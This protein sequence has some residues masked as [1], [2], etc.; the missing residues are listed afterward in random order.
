MFTRKLRSDLRRRR[1]RR[2]LGLESLE[3]RRLLSLGAEFPATVNS[4]TNLAQFDSDNASSANGSS[5]AVWTDT[6]AGTDR[7]IRAQRFNSS[8]G[9]V[10]PEIVVSFSGLDEGTPA[11]AMDAQGN[12]V[13]TWMQTQ[14]GGDTNVLA[15]RFNALGTPVGGVVSVGVGT[16]KEHDPDV[17]MDALGNFVV[18]YTRD[19][20][21]TNPDV[22][23]KRFNVSNALLSVT[24]VAITARAETRPSVAMA[25]NGRFNVVWEEA[26]SSTDHDIH[27]NQYAADAVFLG[28]TPI[29]LSTAND[30]LPSLAMDNSGAS[31]VAWQRAGSG[32]SDIKAVRVSSI[33]FAGGEITIAGTSA[34]ERNPSVAL[35]RTGGSFVVAYD[36]T[37]NFI[38]NRVRVAEVSAFNT[39]TTLDA[40]VRSAPAVSI[41][42]FGDY[43]L[44]YTSNDNGDLNI[45]NRRGRLS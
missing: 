1:T 10:G 28:S 2:H 13:V 36:S 8:G 7:D 30:A 31:V 3:G 14:A 4:K 37:T 29:S 45:R 21:N 38:S 20:N 16:F 19:T 23:A 26:F 18:A 41:N 15:R 11:V 12:F 24:S 6:F 43:L 34:N 35:R 5:V 32:G 25:P 42:G 33:G 39:V 27:L 17:A 22:F 40:G 9:K 44:T